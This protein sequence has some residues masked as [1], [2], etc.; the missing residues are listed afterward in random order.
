MQVL[1]TEVRT[2]MGIFRPPNTESSASTARLLFLPY[3]PRYFAYLNPNLST[4]LNIYTQIQSVPV[5]PR[6]ANGRL[7][8]VVQ[9]HRSGG[10]APLPRI[11]C[12]ES[13]IVVLRPMGKVGEHGMQVIERW[14]KAHGVVGELLARHP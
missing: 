4:R 11:F 10:L 7:V 8:R 14:R 13:H 5:P 2:L 3:R 9:P 6:A 1:S 12:T